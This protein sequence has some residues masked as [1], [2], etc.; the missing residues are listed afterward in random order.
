MWHG[1]AIKVQKPAY[2][3]GGFENKYELTGQIGT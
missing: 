3:E 1:Q 2:S